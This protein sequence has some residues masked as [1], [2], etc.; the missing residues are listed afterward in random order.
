MSAAPCVWVLNLDA[1]T[2]LET[3]GN[4]TPSAAL[5]RVVEIQ[6]QSLTRSLLA[7]GDILLNHSNVDQFAKNRDLEGL[8]GCAWSP[9]PGALGM[10][11]AVG[12]IPDAAPSVEILRAINARPFAAEVR[13]DLIH[14]S[15]VKHLASNLE[16]VLSVIARPSVDNWLLRRSFGAAGRGRRK[17]AAGKPTA[18]E[19]AWIEASLR[20]GPLIIEPWVDVV[21]EFTRSGW[22]GSKGDVTLAPPCLQETK[23]CGAWLRSQAAPADALPRAL[24]DR[25]QEAFEQA[26]RA[27]ARAGYQ[28][29]FGV[30]SYLHKAAGGR[31][32]LNAL[33]EIN[34]RYTMDWAQTRITDPSRNSA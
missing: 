22:V 23:S 16:E 13:K 10:L 26:G 18:P 17:I 9:T 25:L 8:V 12:A 2:E 3:L 14:D 7:P 5:L 34:G 4:Y 15:F 27:I 29:P 20:N 28:G 32:A 21:R 11:A 24:D 30:D 31:L 6:Q 1:E 19:R 33:S